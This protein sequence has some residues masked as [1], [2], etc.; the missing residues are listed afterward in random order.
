MSRKV[1]HH[2]PRIP[3]HGSH[4]ALDGSVHNGGSAR[5]LT[6]EDKARHRRNADYAGH[7]KRMKALQK[8]GGSSE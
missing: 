4:T 8:Y 5:P 2:K 3:K 7:L 6:P 1:K